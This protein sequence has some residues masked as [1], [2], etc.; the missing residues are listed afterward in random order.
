VPAANLRVTAGRRTARNGA[1]VWA[2]EAVDLIAAV[3]PAA[4]IV[5]RVSAEAEHRLR[6]AADLLV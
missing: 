1:P 3:Q 6:A 2:G 4:G 5:T